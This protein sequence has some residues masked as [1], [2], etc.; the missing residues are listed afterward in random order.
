MFATDRG[1]TVFTNTYR[2]GVS[3]VNFY[4]AGMKDEVSGPGMT[5]TAFT[6]GRSTAKGTVL[7][8]AV[9]LVDISN[10]PSGTLINTATLSLVSTGVGGSGSADI[11]A[12][13]GAEAGWVA[14]GDGTYPTWDETASGVSW[15]IAGGSKDNPLVNAGV[16]ST[17]SGDVTF[18]FD[19]TH[20]ASRALRYDAG[21]FN[22]VLFSSTEGSGSQTVIFRAGDHATEAFR[23]LL[24]IDYVIGSGSGA[25]GKSKMGFIQRMRK[26]K[27]I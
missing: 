12:S 10:L 15:A 6:I 17:T 27:R 9:M 26:F 7:Y 3:S 19:V 11:Y 18:T 14:T 23:P 5:G 1:M 20:L 24:T 8:R 16:M 2:Q 13:R 4:D 25:G 22:F 21:I